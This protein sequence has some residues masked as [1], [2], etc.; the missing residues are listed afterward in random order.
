MKR[1][2]EIEIGE[3]RDEGEDRRPGQRA[4]AEKLNSSCMSL[5][6]S[7]AGTHTHA[8]TPEVTPVSECAGPFPARGQAASVAV[9]SVWAGSLLRARLSVTYNRSLHFKRIIP[10]TLALGVTPPRDM[11]LVGAVSE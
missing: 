4:R 2:R 5:K 10:R 7:F 3:R 1:E 6:G 9:P 11:C 8:H